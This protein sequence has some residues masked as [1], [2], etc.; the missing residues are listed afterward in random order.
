MG[1][2][3]RGWRLC[4]SVLEE[5]FSPMAGE[6]SEWGKAARSIGGGGDNHTDRC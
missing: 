5:G 4:F 2:L 6:G 3:I 1:F